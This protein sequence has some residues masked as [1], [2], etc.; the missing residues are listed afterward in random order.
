MKPALFCFALSIAL[1]LLLV[2]LNGCATW[3]K[4]AKITL[5]SAEASVQGADKVGLE[6]YERKCRA[7]ALKCP[8]GSGVDKSCI[9]LQ[10]CHGQQNL[11]RTILDKAS[12]AIGATWVALAA[13]DRPTTTKLLTALQPVLSDL[14]KLLTGIVPGGV[15]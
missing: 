13:G 3:Q 4:T 2:S 12:L 7:V 8:A 14:A 11:L 6:Y 9:S 5:T 1:F 15:L 10:T